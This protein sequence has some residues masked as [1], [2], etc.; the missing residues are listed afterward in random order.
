MCYC[1]KER[2][3][4]ST[5]TKWTVKYQINSQSSLCLFLLIFSPQNSIIRVETT[6]IIAY[7]DWEFPRRWE[8]KNKIKHRTREI[9]NHSTIL[10]NRLGRYLGFFLQT[11]R[12]RDCNAPKSLVFAGY[13]SCL[14]AAK[15][16]DLT[17]LIWWWYLSLFF[18]VGILMMHS[19]T[20]R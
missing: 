16:I 17:D 11:V 10:S 18:I 9:E 15:S 8:I 19:F 2:N 4:P 7:L 13:F 14:S 1:F 12:A 5:N 6:R 3:R 20:R